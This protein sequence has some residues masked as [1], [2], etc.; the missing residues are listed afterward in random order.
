M[1]RRLLLYLFFALTFTS[2]DDEKPEMT[3]TEK[4]RRDSLYLVVR[5]YYGNG[6]LVN[7][8]KVI[9]SFTAF[10]DNDFDYFNAKAK[11]KYNM[12]KLPEALLL[13]NRALKIHPLHGE[14]LVLK[15][16]ALMGLHYEDSSLIYLNKAIML[17]PTNTGYLMARMR[18]NL[19]REIPTL[20]IDDAIACIRIDPANRA[21]YLS[22]SSKAKLLAGDTLGALGD[23]DTIL[24]Y[25][26]NDI[27]GNGQKGFLLFYIRQY[28]EA[29]KYFDKT[30]E[31]TP[32]NGELFLFRASAKGYLKNKAGSCD[33]LEK[34]ILL[35]NPEALKYVDRCE[36]YFKAHGKKFT[37]KTDTVYERQQPN[38]KQI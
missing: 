16:S 4:T 26:P 18:I 6:D 17:N 25:K 15:S 24:K 11:I 10:N 20:V 34:A 9:D 19:D 35:E 13:I 22:A 37:I 12:G 32:N 21:A 8:E 2:C 33:D 14:S 3:E 5:Q 28:S 27:F 36:D 30:I 38:S 1:T 29:I 31:M 23:C 7:A